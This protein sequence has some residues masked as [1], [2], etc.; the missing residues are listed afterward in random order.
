MQGTQLYAREGDMGDPQR[1]FIGGVG[2]LYR[3]KAY[4]GKWEDDRKQGPGE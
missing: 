3:V 4:E 1:L 2:S